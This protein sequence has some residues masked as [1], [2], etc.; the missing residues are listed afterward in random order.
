MKTLTTVFG[1]LSISAF[2]FAAGCGG[3]DVDK[4]I[5]ATE[6]VA[7]EICACEDMDCVKTAQADFQK[8]MAELAKKHEGE[9]SP[10]L[11]EDHKKRM[12]AATTKMTG[13]ITKLTKAEMEKAVEAAKPAAADPAA[14]APE[15]EAAAAEGEA[16]APEGEAAAAEGE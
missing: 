8:E 7:E 16:A 5:E 15:G 12:A 13:C 9:E 3:S 4:A 1:A 14:A 2:L 6:K 11:S 10:E